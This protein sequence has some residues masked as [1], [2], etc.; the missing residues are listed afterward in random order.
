MKNNTFNHVLTGCALAF[1]LA[2]APEHAWAVENP[3][4]WLMIFP[5]ITVVILIIIILVTRKR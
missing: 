5:A 4:R 2:G 3:K 1:V